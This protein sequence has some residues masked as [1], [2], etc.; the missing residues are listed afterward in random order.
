MSYTY[1]L[2]TDIGK[3]RMLLSDNDSQDYTFENE[4]IQALLDLH[5]GDVRQAAAEG[6]ET[7]ARDRAKLAKR[8]KRGGR[9]TER[10]AIADLLAL[11]DRIRDASKYSQSGTV[12]MSYGVDVQDT[13]RPEGVYCELQPGEH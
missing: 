9:E 4:E 12:G 11:A 8:V 1:D 3:V 2:S 7:W 6:Y 10:Q 5:G 13:I